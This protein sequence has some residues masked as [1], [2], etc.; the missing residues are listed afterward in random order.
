[1]FQ[2][3]NIALPCQTEVIGF[4]VGADSQQ[5]SAKS[6]SDGEADYL[7]GGRGMRFFGVN[8]CKIWFYARN[9]A[10]KTAFLRTFDA[11]N[12]Q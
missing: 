1:V 10:L 2:H 5:A 4:A 8:R 6:R 9:Y 12:E 3:P 7:E 11:R